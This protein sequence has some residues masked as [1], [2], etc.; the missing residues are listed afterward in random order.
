M[1]FAAIAIALLAPSGATARKRCGVVSGKA[2][3]GLVV[4]HRGRISCRGARK[5]VAR[6][7]FY[8]GRAVRGWFCFTAHGPS[9]YAGACSPTGQDPDTARRAIRI[10]KR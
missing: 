5:I 6:N 10:Y 9:S 7:F 1:L 4:V 3:R 2:G 8:T